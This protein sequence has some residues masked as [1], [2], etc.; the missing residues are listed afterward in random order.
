M[1][2]FN[3]QYRLNHCRHVLQNAYKI[4]LKHGK[5]AE[6]KEKLASLQDAIEKG[7][8]QQAD[9]LAKR[10]EEWMK[11]KYPKSWLT[12]SIEFAG[13][14]IVA[15][16][17]A[18]VIRQSWFELYEIPTG[19]MRPTFKEQD[20]LTVSKTQFG[21]N[22]PLQ[23]EHFYFDPNLVQRTSTIIFSGDGLALRDTDTTFLGIFPYKKRYVKRL[24]GKPEDSFLF[25]G[26]QLYV[27]DKEGQLI[28]LRTS[29][30]MQKL[31]YIPFISFEGQ[32]KGV[33]RQA[34]V[35]YYFNMP[36]A[37]VTRE[38]SGK[39][40]GEVFNGKEWVADDLTTALT[41]HDSIRTLSDLVGMGNYAMAQL[42][43]KDDLLHEGLKT[44]KDALL[45]LVLRH[46]PHLDFSKGS[47]QTSYFPKM[48]TT[49]L[50]L[51]Q[52]DL[53][54]LMQNMYTARFVIRDGKVNR[55]NLDPLPFTPKSVRFANIPDGTYEFY[56]GKAYQVH[57]GGL[58]TELPANHPLYEVTPEATQLLF[59]LGIGWDKVFQ[60]QGETRGLPNRYA[61]FRE[62]D[63]YVLGAPFWKKDEKKLEAFIE[64]EE[65]RQKEAS[66]QDPYVAFK[67]KGA[68]TA[69]VFQTFGLKIPANQYLVLGDNHAMSGDSRIFGFVP[70]QNLQGVPEIILWP[71]GDRLGY[72]S[73]KPYPTFVTPRLIVWCLAAI[74]GLISYFVYRYRLRKPLNL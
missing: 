8:R 48:L 58:T 30:W 22:V 36:L 16:L 5:P 11:P 23:T 68:P 64:Q 3:R 50:P 28:D 38:A 74:I 71:I 65:K 46:T 42:Y 40:K 35:F 9:I 60:P 39:L 17:V 54:T 73:Q 41:P 34:I 21:I 45:Y 6:L 10:L 52:Q 61:Y 20:H 2:I 7:D 70:E 53:T 32:P 12:K 72:P 1:F 29:S 51:E 31:E 4:Y 62:G 26:G 37:K 27:Q 67:D 25:Y 33:N 13:A 43:T 55:Y 59:N 49:V 63:L 56:Y 15:L 69:A 57:F 14:L 47:S 18:T 44:D 19:S 66:S 24:I